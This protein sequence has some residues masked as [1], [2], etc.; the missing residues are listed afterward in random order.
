MPK[1]KRSLAEHVREYL[2]EN[3]TAYVA[4]LRR[5]YNRYCDREGYPP[6]SYNSARTTVYLLK[7][8]GLVELSHTEPVDGGALE[9]RHY[10]RLTP[11]ALDADWSDPRGQMYG[12]EENQ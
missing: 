3:D 7:R 6:T 2:R 12:R 10:Y 11:G 9:P 8:L 1:R 4:E 5:S